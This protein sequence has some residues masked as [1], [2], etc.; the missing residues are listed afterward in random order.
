MQE[1]AT[2]FSVTVLN[3]LI[4]VI[5]STFNCGCKP[6][7]ENKENKIEL[8]KGTFA[9]DMDFLGKYYNDLVV[10]KDGNAQLIISPALQGR[11]MTSTANGVEGQSFGWLNYDLI[12]SGEQLEHINPY[13]G[14]ERFWLGPE[15]GQFSIYFKQE[16]TFEFANW[17]VPKELDTESFDLVNKDNQKAQFEKKMK[18]VNYSGTVFNCLVDRRIRLIGA[19]EAARELGMNLPEGIQ[20]VGFESKNVLTNT[21]ENTWNKQSGMLSIWILS[22]LNSTDETNVIIPFRTGDESELGKMVTDDYFGKVP[23]DRLIVMDSVLLFKGDGKQRGK[24]GI[25]PYRALPFIGSFDAKNKVLS[26]AKFTLPEGKTDYVNSEWV[27]QE[28]P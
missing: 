4:L 3:L 15:G 11:V 27:H 17:Y 23:E 26:V 28:Y 19:D 18:L 6:N 21:G 20:M 22:M 5:I 9:Y 10:L 13:G 14:E 25:S 7:K 12:A 24:I 2:S 16:T 1:K 8:T